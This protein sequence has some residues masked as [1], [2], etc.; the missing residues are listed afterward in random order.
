MAKKRRRQT[1]KASKQAPDRPRTQISFQQI[2]SAPWFLPALALLGLLMAFLLFDGNLSLSGD[3]AQ[4]INLGRS[5][6]AGYGLSE[7][8]G[9]EPTP[10]T[11]Y[12]F[13]FPVLLAI[14][15]LL[16]P[17]SLTA[18][19][20]LI[21]LLYALSIPLIY[22][23]IRTYESPP[24]ALSVCLICLLSPPL[25]DFSHQ[26]MSEIPY[27]T[28]SLMALLL[29]KKAG[30]QP[31]LRNLII[32]I[33]AIM[34]TYYIRTAGVV[35]V[36]TGILYF[37]LRKQYKETGI[38]AGGCLLLAL[39]WTLRNASLGSADYVNQLLSINPYRP[40]E[41]LLTLPTLIERIATNLQIYFLHVIPGIFV[42]SW[43][44]DFNWPLGLIVSALLLHA[45]FHGIKNAR[46]PAVYLTCHLGLHLLWPQVWSDIRFLLPAIPIF[47]YLIFKS[48]VHLLH[49][50]SERVSGLPTRAILIALLLLNLL[51]NIQATQ[52]LSERN[53]SFPPNWKSYFQAGDWIRQNTRDDV[54]IACRK[55]FLMNA[56]ANRKTTGYVWETP[57]GVIQ[58]FEQK[59]VDIVVVDQLGF[60]STPRYLVPAVNANKNRFQL[61][62]QIPNSNT[63]ILKFVHTP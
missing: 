61:L 39:P 58:D 13:G 25:L 10:H 15:H 35:L 3:N 56:T 1:Q 31:K 53:G 6:A 11:K 48:A 47:L 7:T 14:V 49:Q 59:G 21:C 36:G 45:L 30:D 4:F 37:L 54:K 42:P 8:L 38:L 40:D 50:L 18:L 16:I 2:E 28:A 55:P 17:G 57:D 52:H 23:F 12:P 26:V 5:L 27:L 62:R 63:F 34:A 9:D 43:I 29:L 51:S 33:F 24:L 20:G 41:G 22:K 44:T 32:G 60:S 19:K 46:L